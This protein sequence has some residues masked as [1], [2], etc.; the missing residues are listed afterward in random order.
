MVSDLFTFQPIG[1]IPLPITGE[2]GP[3]A[4]I[5]L[6]KLQLGLLGVWKL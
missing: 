1:K 6:T 5:W 2:L 3:A 4:L